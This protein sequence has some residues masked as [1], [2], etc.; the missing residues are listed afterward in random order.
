LRS[1]TISPASDDGIEEMAEWQPVSYPQEG[2]SFS[3]SRFYLEFVFRIVAGCVSV[4][5]PVPILM[6]W[7]YFTDWHLT[8]GM[9][10]AYACFVC[11]M[12]LGAEHFRSRIFERVSVRK[13]YSD[14]AIVRSRINM[15]VD[16]RL[17]SGRYIVTT[18]G[19][20]SYLLSM[21]K[22]ALDLFVASLCLFAIF[23]GLMLLMILVRIESPGPALVSYKRRGLNGRIFR[24]YKLRTTIQH[25]KDRT[26]SAEY[27]VTMVGS[28]LRRTAFDQLPT[29]INIIKGDMSLVGPRPRPLSLDDALAD[30]FPQYG[31]R[32]FARPGL[33]GLNRRMYPQ[34]LGEIVID[35]VDYVRQ[36]SFR[37]DLAILGRALMR[38]FLFQ[39]G[40]T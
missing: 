28:S 25:K 30:K 31:V 38:S 5:I 14:T 1:L 16:R 36:G 29:L 19:S 9:L 24:L 7:G 11:G 4:I 35:D 12:I 26:S 15:S 10:W 22:R 32:Y 20:S 33:I 40:S 27:K 18:E 8:S 2:K 6:M 37:M 3:R 13:G 21:R 17:I 23:P 39:A 34:D